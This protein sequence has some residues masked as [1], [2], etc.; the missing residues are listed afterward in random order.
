MKHQK[1]TV[2]WPIVNDGD[3]KQFDLQNPKHEYNSVFSF[4]VNS[5]DEYGWITAYSATH[6]L[7]LG[8]VW[9][10][11]RLSMAQSLATF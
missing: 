7:V 4:I 11:K 10:R 5:D 8:Y 2:N 6:Q 3:G 1:I 9:Q